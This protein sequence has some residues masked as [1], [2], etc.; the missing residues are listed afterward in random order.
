[1]EQFKFKELK[2]W[3]KALEFASESMDVTESMK[4]HYRIAEQLEAAAA[5]VAQNIA[6]GDGRQTVKENIQY[7]NISRG[8]LNEA[9]TVLNL[10]CKR[11]L[12]SQEK[13]T[14][15]EAM[16]MEIIKMINS[17]VTHKRKLIQK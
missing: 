2:V 15:M 6:E 7:L 1:M 9:I 16:G 14:E 12:M 17:L 11:R 13:L 5:S 3:N 10:L 8:S 4:G